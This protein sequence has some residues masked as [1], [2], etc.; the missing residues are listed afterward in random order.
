[1]NGFCLDTS[2]VLD[3]HFR[4]YPRRIF[5]TLWDNLDALVAEGRL[6]LAEDVM[7]E[8]APVEDDAHKWAKSLPAQALIPLSEGIQRRTSE[9]L[10][11]HP[12]LVRPNKP[13]A[14]SQADPFVIASAIEHDLVVVTAE[15]RSGDPK[16]PRIPDCCTMMGVACA[17]VVGMFDT[18]GWR[19]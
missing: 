16:Y 12:N 1:M 9:I 2:A 19:L 13:K 5:S 17:N 11:H 3:L 15:Q 10:A 4:R 7:N 6:K 8:L 18:L 14:R